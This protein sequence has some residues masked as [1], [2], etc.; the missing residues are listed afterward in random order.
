MQ[1]EKDQATVALKQ[2]QGEVIDQCRVA[3]Q[4][5]VALQTNFKKEKAQI[6]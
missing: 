5:K 4:E 3:H 1:E 6:Q 2:A